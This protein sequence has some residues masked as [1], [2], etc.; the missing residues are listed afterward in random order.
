MMTPDDVNESIGERISEEVW[1]MSDANVLKELIEFDTKCNWM[2]AQR[3]YLTE[4]LVEKYSS[5]F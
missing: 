2:E 1:E 4:L 5:R 3:I